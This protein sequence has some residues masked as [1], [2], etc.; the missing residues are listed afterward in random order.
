MWERERES[1]QSRCTRQFIL[2][3]YQSD[4]YVFSPFSSTKSLHHSNNE[5]NPWE[6]LSP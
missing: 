5:Y 4:S 6:Y 2:I 3:H 1:K